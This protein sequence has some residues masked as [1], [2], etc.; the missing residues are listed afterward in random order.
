MKMNYTTLEISI[1][2]AKAIVLDL[3]GIEGELIKLDGCVDFNFKV[4]T[5]TK[6]QYILKISRPNTDVKELDFQ[7]KLLQYIASNQSILVP[8]IVLNKAQEGMST[9][10]DNQGES[11]TVR[12]LTWI[13]GRL[14]SGLNP[15]T[16]VLRHQLGQQ[17]GTLTSALDG[18][19]H[20][21]AH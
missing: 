1:K 15:Q 19:D 17:A 12:L 2:E 13:K 18:F 21:Q 8:K 14:W 5:R 16:A 10:L 20:P 11:R 6:D 3:Y 4:K 7:Q 9:F